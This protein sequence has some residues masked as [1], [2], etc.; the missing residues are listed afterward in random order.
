VNEWQ[1]AIE[2]PFSVLWLS[3]SIKEIPFVPPLRCKA[4]PVTIIATGY[5]GR[6]LLTSSDQYS[7]AIGKSQP[8]QESEDTSCR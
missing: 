5:L 1:K 6:G 3:L 2:S 4:Y 7:D 8:E